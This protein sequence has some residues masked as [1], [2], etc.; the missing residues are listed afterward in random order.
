MLPSLVRSNR[1]GATGAAGFRAASFPWDERPGVSEALWDSYCLVPLEPDPA[2]HGDR[3][4]PD[5]LVAHRADKSEPAYRDVRPCFPES[6]KGGEHRRTPGYHVVNE[7]DGC[8]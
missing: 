3:I 7:G 4:P 2:E 5:G 8:A 6:G 1:A